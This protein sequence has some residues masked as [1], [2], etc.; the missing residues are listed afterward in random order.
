M[1]PMSDGASNP[2]REVLNERDLRILRLIFHGHSNKQIAEAMA[3]T[4]GTVR[5]YISQLFKRLGVKSRTAAVFAAI[6]R[7]YLNPSGL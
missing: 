4:H 6:E 3:F 2:V 7:G 1:A 5:V